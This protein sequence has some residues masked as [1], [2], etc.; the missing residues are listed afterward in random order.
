MPSHAIC[1]AAAAHLFRILAFVLVVASAAAGEE[2]IEAPGPTGPLKG[3]VVSSADSGPVAIIIPGSGPTDRDGNG[4]VLQ[5]SLYRLLADGLARRDVTT[6]RID[7]RGLFS[8]SAAVPDANAVTM[9]D[10][11]KD[12]STWVEVMRKRMGASCIWLIGHSEGAL[13][14]LH[15]A[16]ESKDICGLVLLASPGRPAGDVLRDQMHRFAKTREVLDQALAAIESLETGRKVD[17]T[18]MHPA[19]APVFREEVQG[20]LIS[21]LQPEPAA[22][23]RAYAGPVLIL[24]GTRDI[25]VDTIDADRLAAAN[26]SARLVILSDTNHVFKTVST[27]S[28][29]DNLATYRNPELPLAT[30]VLEAVSDFL[31]E[32]H[33]T[34]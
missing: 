8:S 29:A 1:R 22:L 13:V 28:M 31:Q 2:E 7:K 9:D 24:Q 20:F 27:D 16:R 10:Y 33:D 32:H 5:T 17:T 6:V 26:P 21:F 14:A 18:K 30:N 4:P 11:A 23:I 25:Q 19:L 12:V 3:L 34:R 15:T